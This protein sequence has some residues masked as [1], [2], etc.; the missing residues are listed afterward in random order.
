VQK[1]YVWVESKLLMSTPTWLLL[2]SLYT[3][4]WNVSIS[5]AKTWLL[6][7]P[8]VTWLKRPSDPLSK[9]VG[10]LARWFFQY[11]WSHCFL[12]EQIR[13]SD[14][15]IP[16]D[17]GLLLSGMPPP[18]SIIQRGE[19]YLEPWSTPRSFPSL[20][21]WRERYGIQYSNIGASKEEGTYAYY[22][23]MGGKSHLWSYAS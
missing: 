15:I 14:K 23:G 19:Y 4:F 21:V 20:F 16:P 18:S 3:R 11:M 2:G 7:F 6:A 10:G 13:A 9:V 1:S 22:L 5:T 8:L 12:V 17:L